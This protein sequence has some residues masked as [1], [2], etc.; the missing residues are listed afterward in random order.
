MRRLI[1][2]LIVLCVSLVT[3]AQII[4]D[5]SSREYDILFHEAMLQ[6]QQRHHDAAFDLLMRCK[7]LCPEASETYYFLAQ[8]Y[9]GMKQNDQALAAFEKAAELEPA[10]A[11]YMETLSDAYIMQKRYGDA[12]LVVKKLYEA[13]KSRE[14]LLETLYHLYTGQEMY[15][16]A[17]DVLD[18]LEQNNG[19]TER[20][21]LAKSRLYLQ[22][23]E[24]DK[25]ALEMKELMEQHP[26]DLNYKTLYANAMMING[27]R[28]EAVKLL[29]QVLDEEP[30]NIRAQVALKGYY[31]SEEDSSAVMDMTRRIL[32]NPRATT[33]DKVYQMR[34]L[35]ALNED[36]DGD[37]TQILN[38][39]REMLN[40]PTPDPDI[41]ELTAAYMDLKKMPRDSIAQALELVLRLAPE[42]TTPRLQ[43][44]QYAWENDDNDSIISLCQAARQ[45]NPEEMAFYY[46]QGMAY[47]RQDDTDHALEA[48]QNGISVINEDSSPEIVSD[49]YAVMGDLLFL[50]DR[51]REAFEAYDS[52]LQWKPDNIGCLN[53]YAYYLSLDGE[54]LEQAE[55]MSYKTIKAQPT[56][57]T[58][59]DTYAWIL[60]MEGR[61]AEARIYIDQALQND[62]AV[63]AVVTEHAGDIYALSGDMEGAITLWRQALEMDSQNKLLV[64][65]LK[66]KKYFKK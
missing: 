43:L 53:N 7:E 15:E 12:V 18:K 45:Y 30:D 51:K 49:F 44:V 62:S 32:L 41:A 22:L 33:E 25:S 39:F 28:D 23:G 19:K 4:S 29:Y 36:S 50:K 37:S 21:A 52:C 1:V 20:I 17:I 47:Y 31:S 54:N 55:L 9:S 13:D 59:L 3:V 66:K 64:R 40:Q 8:Y 38:L 46:Y 5:F 61:Y 58:Y 63:G 65:K 27:Q 57:S 2:F 14:E 11:T 16:E 35:I 48:F 56:N 26:N 24:S 6:R 34:S 10:N 60:F 42:R